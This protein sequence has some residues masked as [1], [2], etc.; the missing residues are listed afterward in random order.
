MPLYRLLLL[1]FVMIIIEVMLHILNIIA[2]FS[3]QVICH[4]TGYYH[5][6]YH[7]NLSFI[8]L[9]YLER[10]ITW[11]ENFGVRLE[12]VA[13]CYHIFQFKLVRIFFAF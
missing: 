9:C 12:C 1:G 5:I 4:L 10:Y 11:N 6:I 7:I 2:N 13:L 3:S 8:L